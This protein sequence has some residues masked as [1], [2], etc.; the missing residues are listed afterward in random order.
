MSQ[1][2]FVSISFVWIL[3]DSSQFELEVVKSI[4]F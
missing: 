3:Q 2:I 1:V 4:D